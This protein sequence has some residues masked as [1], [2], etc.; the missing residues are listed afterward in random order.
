MEG[1]QAKFNQ[2]HDILDK[3]LAKQSFFVELEKKTGFPKV[4]VVLGAVSFVFVLIF[5]NL[6]GKII[7]DLLGWVYPAYSSFKAIETPG[8][9]DDKQWLTYWTVFGFVNIVEYFSDAL[10]F[11]FPFYYLFKTLFVL[12]LA[13]PSF[14]G[15][16]ILYTSGLRQLLLQY[17]PKVDAQAA[18]LRANAVK[19]AEGKSI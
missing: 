17:A 6:G 2:Y 16:E 14:R 15:A 13:L 8:H 1:V 5:F 12:W 9:D 7:T 11:W 18:Q 3:E 4:T 10:L 19:V